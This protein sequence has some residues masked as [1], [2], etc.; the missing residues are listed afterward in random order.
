M[1]DNV[2]DARLDQRHISTWE[3]FVTWS[4]C[5]Y[6]CTLVLSCNQNSLPGVAVS[7]WLR[8]MLPIA[9]ANPEANNPPTDSHSTCKGVD[10][11]LIDHAQHLKALL[12]ISILLMSEL[13]KSASSTS[14]LRGAW[15]CGHGMLLLMKHVR[16]AWMAA[17]F[18]IFFCMCMPENMATEWSMCVPCR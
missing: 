11:L 10:I 4:T 15:F 16:T 13:S 18:F 6:S 12:P 17:G 8:I 1:Q 9:P 5:A 2:H 14:L 3:T 7:G